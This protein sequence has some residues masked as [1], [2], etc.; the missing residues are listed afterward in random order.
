MPDNVRHSRAVGD[1][2]QPIGEALGLIEG[3]IIDGL[4]H[5]HF[6]FSVTCETGN[7]GRRLLIIRAGKSY[8]F[9]VAEGDLPK[10]R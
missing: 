7:S 2:P 8:K 1:H 6:D 4:I 10:S 9:T 5:G 3:L